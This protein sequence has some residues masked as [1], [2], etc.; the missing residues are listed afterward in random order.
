MYNLFFEIKKFFDKNSIKNIAFKNQ[1]PSQTLFP[2]I[3]LIDWS[4]NTN[5]ALYI[6][7]E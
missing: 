4:K 3:N 5:F 1:F 2:K 7:F 6:S